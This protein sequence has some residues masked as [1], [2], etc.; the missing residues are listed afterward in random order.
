MSFK[1]N[2]PYEKYNTFSIKKFKVGVVSVL[3]GSTFFVA[4]GVALADNLS[5]NTN[6]NTRAAEVRNENGVPGITLG[7]DRAASTENT[8]ASNNNEKPR[9]LDRATVPANYDGKVSLIGQWTR[10][11]NEKKDTENT[12]K[13]VTDKLGSPLPNP[14]LFRGIAKTFLGWSDKPPVDG[15]IAEG[16]RLFSPEDTLATAFADGLKADSKLYGVY[17]SL[18]D[19]DKPF[20]TSK[21]SMGFAIING[22]R[23]FEINGNKVKI[24][25]NV[26]SEDVLPNT[27]LKKETNDDKTNTRRIIDEYQPSNNDTTKVN[28]VVLKSEFEMDKTTAMLVYKNPWVGYVG[29]VLSNSYKGNKFEI[30]EVEKTYTYVDLNVKLDK[31][32]VIPE[33]LYAEFNGYSWRP[34][35][36][37]GIKEDGTKEILNVYSKDGVALGNTKDSFN[38]LVSNTNPSVTFGVETKGYKNITFRMILRSLNDKD[39]DR[40]ENERN[41]R[42]A[43]SVVKPDEGKSIAETIVRNMTL[44]SLTS[45]EL[46]ALFPNKSDEEINQMVVRINQEKAKELADT[47]GTTVLKVTGIVE[48][49]AH[50]NAGRIGSGLF[51]LDS[52]TNLAINKVEANVLEL[53]YVTFY[54]VSYKFVSGTPDK[55]LP[56]AIEGYKP[57]DQNRYANQVEINA[58]QP[59]ETEYVDAANDGKWVFKSY[60]AES[61]KVN[62]ADVEFIGKW[63]FEA[64]KYGVTYKFKS[65]T[66]GK[67]LPAAIEDYKPTDQNR[68]VDKANV[69][70]TQPTKT[71]YVD[72]ENDGKWVFKSYDAENKEVNKADVEFIG[73]WGFTANKYGVTYKF[74]SG[75]EGK[76]LPVA[77]EGYKPTDSNRYVDKANVGATQPTKTEYVDAENDGKWVF[78]SYDAKN[79]AVNKADVEFIGTWV[80]EA[81]KYGVT[82]KFE[83]GTPGKTLP[84]AIE[85]YKPTDQNRYADKANV[86]AT[87]PTTTE[88]VDAENDGKWVFKSYDAENKAVNKAD[89]EFLGT[90]VFTANKYGVT[91]KFESGTEGKELPKNITELT[92]TDKKEYINGSEVKADFPSTTDVKDGKGSWVFKGYKEE[93]KVINKENIQFVGTWEYIEKAPEPKPGPKPESKPEPKPEPKPGPKPEPNPGPNPQPA[94]SSSS[95]PKPEPKP[96]PTPEIQSKK[97]GVLPNTG[98]KTSNVEIFGVLVAAGA[99]MMRRKRNAK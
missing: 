72:A 61:K 76:D 47:N 4:G 91:Y 1:K 77:I 59:T 8:E 26:E 30:D 93:K 45:T 34:L 87:Q 56:T 81:N 66:E 82:Y 19:Q 48:G 41:E 86:G 54:N 18:N 39:S 65:G 95:E 13:N 16:A 28:E 38:S 97:L 68:Y 64:N 90:W 25:T 7:S 3:V 99:I 62:K 98:E 35:Y 75:T 46:K 24:D 58:T 33:K 79:K 78:T 31:D 83:S 63:E 32:L 50:P 23:K 60:D 84:A 49:N 10:E 94:P 85:G 92:P 67:D 20:P 12:Y 51:S 69:G 53:G 2:T 17:A 73:T 22:M 70:A 11:S 89:V 9:G 40:P 74:K 43:E 80:F 29:P 55:T 52:A 27:K 37:L 6:G 14:G 96:E 36:A 42:I 15:K 57:T 71:E 5:E 44:R 21:F 88:Y